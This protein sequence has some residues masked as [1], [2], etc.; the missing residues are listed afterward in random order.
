MLD[1]TFIRE[2][3][4]IVRTALKNKNREGIDLDRLLQLADER[5]KVATEISDINRKRNEAQSQRDAEAGKRLK[6]ELKAAEEK[7][8]TLE[9]EIIPILVKVPNIPSADTPLGPDE[10]GNQVIRQ[11]G[12]KKDFGFTPK[13]HW[14]IGRELGIIDSEKA[15]EVSGARFTYLKGD[16]AL[17]QFALLQ[18]ALSVLTS[19]E[20]LQKIILKVG[21]QVDAKPFIPVI[22]PVFMRSQVMSR[23]ARLDP[24]DDRFYFEKDDLVLIGSAEHTLG[25]LHMDETITEDRFPI[26]YVGYSTAFRREAGAAGKDTRGILRQHQFD[27]LEMECFVKPEDGLQEQDFLVAIQ[28]HLMQLLGL[29]YQTVLVCTGD[30]GF[31]DQRQIDIETWMPGQNK[32]RETHSADYVGGFQA[33]RLQTKIKRA[34]GETEPVHMNDATVIAIGRTLIA[35]L[36]NYQ[37]A[38]GSV[39]IPEVL[40][41]YMGNKEKIE[42]VSI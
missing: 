31:P 7:Y 14:E 19:R 39:V 37:Q 16:L 24:I 40:R 27:K 23:M 2:N 5:K 35:I 1:I 26:R 38:D 36:E 3:L 30:M 4:D 25:P 34:N 32:Y 11:W 21:L 22:P 17:M 33:R 10:S 20:E 41:P 9:K 8:Q 29:P 42:K 13:A 6:D 18:M 12:E 15:G 28:E